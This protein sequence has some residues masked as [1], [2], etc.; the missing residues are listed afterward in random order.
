MCRLCPFGRKKSDKGLRVQH[1]FRMDATEE[2]IVKKKRK[3]RGK[4]GRKTILVAPNDFPGLV[5]RPHEVQGHCPHFLSNKSNLFCL[6]WFKWVSVICKIICS[7]MLLNTKKYFDLY[8]FSGISVILNWK[9][10][11]KNQ[12]QNRTLKLKSSFLLVQTHSI[13]VSKQSMSCSVTKS[14]IQ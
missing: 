8:M 1:S 11:S 12:K 13:S 5:P 3:E 7:W 4:K 14:F 9:Y 10:N 6:N 2:A